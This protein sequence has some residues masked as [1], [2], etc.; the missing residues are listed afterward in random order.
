VDDSTKIWYFS[1]LLHFVT[2]KVLD[3]KMKLF[4]KPAGIVLKR[5]ALKE[6]TGSE[7]K[8]VPYSLLLHC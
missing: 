8:Q 7:I 3:K 4:P 6:I 1:L 5:N 2:I